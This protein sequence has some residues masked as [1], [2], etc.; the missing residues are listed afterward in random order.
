MLRYLEHEK[1]AVR[2][3]SLYLLGV[4]L[5]FASWTSSYLFLPE[6]ILSIIELHCNPNP[7]GLAVLCAILWPAMLYLYYFLLAFTLLA[8]VS[9]I[10]QGWRNGITPM[11]SSRR[12]ALLM[13]RCAAE[14]TARLD[15]EPR[16]GQ[17]A[18]AGRPIYI[19]ETGSGWGGVAI[20]LARKIPTAQ[21]VGF[22]NSPL[23]Y[24]FS[25]LRARLHGC[26]RVRFRFG[27]YRKAD[28]GKADVIVAYL[29]PKGMRDLAQL[30]QTGSTKREPPTLISNS[31]ALPGSQPD[32]NLQS[33]DASLSPIYVYRSPY[34]FIET[35]PS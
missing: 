35:T 31:F 27:D 2:F 32:R 15:S 9:V 19:I 20:A 5:F 10:Y 6:G 8:A 7:S 4:V 23:P 17:A 34:I 11:P 28:L 1:V 21:I 14:E 22:E 24:L 18:A 30:I 16:T 25:A 3:L 33:G 29:F 13:V 12:A 26:G